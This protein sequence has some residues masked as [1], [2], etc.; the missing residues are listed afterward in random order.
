MLSK[1]VPNPSSFIILE[2][3]IASF[4]VSVAATSFASI[5]YCAIRPCRPTLKLIGALA[6]KTRYEDADLTVL[7]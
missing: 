2:Q 4:L 6:R 5:V 1:R 7:W 3:N